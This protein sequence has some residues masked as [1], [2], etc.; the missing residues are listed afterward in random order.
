MPKRQ[1]WTLLAML[2]FEV[3]LEI[4]TE[5]DDSTRLTTCPKNRQVKAMPV[6]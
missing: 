4:T 5:K 6:E 1:E 3:C 2:L